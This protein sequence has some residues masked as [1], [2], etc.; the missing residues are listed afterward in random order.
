MREGFAGR[1]DLDEE[2]VV[3]DECEGLSLVIKGVLC[4]HQFCCHARDSILSRIVSMVALGGHE[5]QCSNR[6]QNAFGES[7][8]TP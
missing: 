3:A 4:E 7:R 2:R 5:S 1:R 6:H 8:K